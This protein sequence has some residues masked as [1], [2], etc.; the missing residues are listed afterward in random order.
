LLGCSLLELLLKRGDI[1]KIYLLNRKGSAAQKERQRAGFK[2]AGL[3]PGVLDTKK[4]VIVYLDIDLSR[5]DLGLSKEAYEEVSPPTVIP[6]F[7]L[8]YLC[9]IAK[10]RD[11]VTHIIHAAWD[12]NFN[13]I[14]ES[15]ERVHIAGVRHLIDLALSS[16]QAQTPRLTFLSS[17]A[18][19]GAY[20]GETLVPEEPIDDP[21][22]ALDQGYGQGK[23]V[24]ERLLVGAVQA[25]L[26]TT[27]L[28]VTQ[29]SGVTTN[30]AWSLSVHVPIVFRSSVALG[31]IPSDF[32]VSVFCA[33]A[34]VT[35]LT[36]SESPCDGFHRTLRL[37]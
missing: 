4:D 7:P 31:M 10:V 26:R 16:P 1:L 32:P 15:Y 34:C 14:L 3:D 35:M 29:L 20:R 37:R 28:R 9:P 30:G 33:R 25:G 6:S 5:A 18:A 8:I 23:Y 36:R 24:S 19:I 13:L 12:L 2:N 21:S 11:N 22:I 17:I 27:I